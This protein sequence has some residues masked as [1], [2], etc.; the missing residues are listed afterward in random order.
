MPDKEKIRLNTS[1]SESEDG[2]RLA[3]ERDS[4]EVQENNA[5]SNVVSPDGDDMAENKVATSIDDE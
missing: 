1:Q 4:G 3:E 5:F 2:E